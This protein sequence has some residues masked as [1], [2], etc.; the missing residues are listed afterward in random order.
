MK[1]KTNQA[2]ALVGIALLMLASDGNALLFD[3]AIKEVILKAI[4]IEPVAPKKGK[5]ESESCRPSD[6]VYGIR[7]LSDYLGVSPPTAQKYVN[8]GLLD[9][10]IRRVGRKYSFLKSK[11]D[12]AFAKRTD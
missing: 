6:Y 12:E 3:E 4:G 7:G 1:D 10:A 11:V 5:E 8:S 9:G 2:I